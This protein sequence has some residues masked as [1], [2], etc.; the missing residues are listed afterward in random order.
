MNEAAQLITLPSGFVFDRAAAAAHVM[1]PTHTRGVIS[2]RGLE[3]GVRQFPL[4]EMPDGVTLAFNS[5]GFVAALNTA[6]ANSTAGYVMQLRQ[7]G[8]PIASARVAWAK[9]PAD[10]AEPWAQPVRMHIASCSKL[11]TAIAMTRTL[12]AHNLPASTKI[13]DYLPTY[14]TKGP[15]IDKITFAELM[16]HTSGFRVVGS[17]MSYPTMK[18][19]VAAGVTTANLRPEGGRLWA[20]SCADA[21]AVMAATALAKCHADQ[22]ELIASAEARAGYG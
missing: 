8:Q 5:D 16:T 19:Q 17:D 13:I 20:A 12:A 21:M 6:L 10:G 4:R 9:R 18:A 1:Q 14:W 15:N 22:Q 3:E 2:S 7:H 11:I